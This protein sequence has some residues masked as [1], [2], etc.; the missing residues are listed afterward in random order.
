[1]LTVAEAV[2]SAHESLVLHRDLKPANILI[3]A[4]NRPHVSDFGVAK[5]LD[6]EEPQATATIA[7]ARFGVSMPPDQQAAPAQ[8]LGDDRSG[9]YGSGYA[10]LPAHGPGRSIC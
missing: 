5:L 8:Q 6:G 10:V 7:L 9:M 1:M 4:K 3:D 2:Q